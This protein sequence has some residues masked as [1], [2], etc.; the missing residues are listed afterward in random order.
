MDEKQCG[1][2][3]ITGQCKCKPNV[4]GLYCD[5]CKNGYWGFNQDNEAGCKGNVGREEK[6]FGLEVR[7]NP[8][9]YSK[10]QNAHCT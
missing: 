3:P 10:A 4:E 1:H 8:S 2:D 5:Q 7:C 6:H 9:L